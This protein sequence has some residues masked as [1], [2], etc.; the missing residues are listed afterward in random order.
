MADPKN[1]LPGMMTQ[2][3]AP[4][5][6]DSQDRK[7]AVR[8]QV[9]RIVA[10]L[11]KSLPSNY[12][13]QVTGPFYTMQLQAVAEVIADFQVTA[14]EIF[15]DSSYDFTRSEVLF[16][17]LGSLVFPDANSTD[18]WPTIDGDITYRTFLQ[19]MVV[20]LLQGSTKNSVQG[21]IE[22]LTNASVEV[23]ERAVA[24]RQL[25]GNH[26]AWGPSDQFTFEV[27]V[28]GSRSFPVVDEAHTL[29]D[30]TFALDELGIDPSTVR[31]WSLDRLTEYYGPYSYG[32]T[33]DFSIIPEDN[34][35]HLTL[36]LT[37][38]S[39]LSLGLQVLVDYTR[40][41]DDFAENP[42]TLQKNV[43]IVMRALKPAHTLYEYRNL[44]H[45]VFSPLIQSE[46][47][48]KLDLSLFRYEDVRK[49]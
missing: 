39:R 8:S 18:G 1:I 12:V 43:A 27:N 34:A 29:T 16:Q 24:A 21:G 38:D 44:F 28:T 19:R 6:A 47:V 10:T 7:T 37:E 30:Y 25:K 3:P 17:I 4:F 14:Q 22:A 45:E 26:S 46:T 15:A 40:S 31:V 11:M 35:A 2:N 33:R 42:Y 20:L 23:I 48:Q 13:S 9:D 41:I 49:Y 32:V 36:E 5:T